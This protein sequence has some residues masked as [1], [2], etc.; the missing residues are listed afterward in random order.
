[1]AV[2]EHSQRRGRAID[3]AAFILLELGGA[4]TA[5]LAVEGGRI[6]DGVGGSSGPLGLHA[7]GGLDGEVAFV[8]GHVSKSM[9]F[10]GGAAAI[11]GDAHLDPARSSRHKVAWDAYIEAA[12]K[13][14]AGL[15]VSAPNAGEVILSGRVARVPE[16]RDE[17][18]RRLRAI[19]DA[20]GVEALE[21][22]AAS[23]MQ[24]AQG[25]ALLA[26][27]LAGGAHAGLVRTLG[28][29]DA[30]G[31]VLDYLYVVSA[32]QARRTLGIE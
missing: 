7:A 12:V 5:A 2:H 24:A 25:A 28:I 29:R 11:A 16:V 32:Q 14:V 15:R 30:A 13:A 27:G 21:G 19:D 10:R 3:E 6:V 23:A 4:F 22:F 8:A 18:A 1:L 26:D 31:T 17:L 20:L 9:I